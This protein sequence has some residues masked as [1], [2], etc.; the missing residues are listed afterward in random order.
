MHA[1]RWRWHCLVAQLAQDLVLHVHPGRPSWG[2][3][4]P[5]RLL[6]LHTLRA[7]LPWTTM[8]VPSLWAHERVRPARVR[9]MRNPG[10]DGPFASLRWSR[11]GRSQ[12]F[13]VA[14]R[15]GGGG[16]RSTAIPGITVKIR[17][18]NT[19]T[20]APSGDASVRA[21]GGDYSGVSVQKEGGIVGQI[22]Y[23]RWAPG[24]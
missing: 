18:L 6:H 21:R 14:R 16:A 1:Y 4:V 5:V 23:R 11:V 7:L 22:T 9:C 20:S 24:Q 12:S 17:L 10:C 19:A 13:G 2:I 8:A 3:N 15:R